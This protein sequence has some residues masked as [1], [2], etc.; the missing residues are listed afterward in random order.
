MT[1]PI[2]PA[3]LV[4][5][6]LLLGVVT[7]AGL[8]WVRMHR[9]AVVGPP[10]AAVHAL[11]LVVWLLVLA[12]YFVATPAAIARSARP[13]AGVAWP[14]REALCLAAAASVGPLVVVL[15][16]D[17][18]RGF[19]G[20]D[21]I[22]RLPGFDSPDVTMVVLAHLLASVAYVGAIA[23]MICTWRARSWP[24]FVAACLVTL[25]CAAAVFLVSWG[26]LYFE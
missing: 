9:P 15:A 21:L 19:A 11:S 3:V 22:G 16:E 18:P 20:H 12:T 2:H 17:A 4:G 25:A 23:R 10:G 7:L 5:L 14:I 24:R 1:R 6:G 13:P 26:I 8:G